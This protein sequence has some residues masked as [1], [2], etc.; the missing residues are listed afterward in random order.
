MLEYTEGNAMPKI[1]DI[2]EVTKDETEQ[3]TYLP[4]LVLCPICLQIG[5]L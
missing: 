4:A 5:A 1:K 3:V 2:E